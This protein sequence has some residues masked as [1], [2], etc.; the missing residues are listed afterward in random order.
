MPRDVPFLLR[1]YETKDVN[2]IWTTEH[3]LEYKQNQINK[4][5]IQ[6]L[7]GIINRLHGRFNI[8]KQQKERIIYLIK[9]LDFYL[10]RVTEEQYIVMI[11]VYVKLETDNNARVKKYYKILDNYDIP[12]NTFIIFLVRL[13]RHHINK[14]PLQFSPRS[15]FNTIKKN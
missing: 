6:Y 7:D 3:E 13:N 2:E 1:K 11:L 9:E 10:G 14:I 4:Q 15:S 12:L 5:R 8:S